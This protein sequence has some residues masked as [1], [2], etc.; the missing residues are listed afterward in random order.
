MRV[1]VRARVLEMGGRPW[2][3]AREV[4]LLM[5]QFARD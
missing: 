3:S 1:R 5:R 4:R 2:Q